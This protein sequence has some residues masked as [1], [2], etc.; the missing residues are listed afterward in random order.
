MLQNE[1][2]AY[3][4]TDEARAILAKPVSGWLKKIAGELEEHTIPIC[5][6]HNV[7]YSALSLNSYLS[8]SDLDVKVEARDIFAVNEVTW[9]IDTI[10][11]ILVGLL[12][13]GSGIAMIA[14]GPQGIIVGMIVSILVLALGQEKMQ[15]ALLN[16]NLPRVVRMLVPKGSFESRMEKLS[17]EIKD[18][19]YSDL[20]NEK[21]EEI[22][23][24]LV[25]EISEQIEICL[26]KMAEVV[27]IPLSQK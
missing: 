19:L 23:G 17:S 27:E 4:H 12:C 11:S 14:N 8:L 21:N 24:R 25:K 2:D 6:R 10:V 3:L 13:G 5:V 15:D 16:I 1:I 20:E 9:M 26:A 22:S 18:R 7:P